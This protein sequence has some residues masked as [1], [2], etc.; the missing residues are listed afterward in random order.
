VHCG[1]SALSQAPALLLHRCG[2]KR[3]RVR[4]SVRAGVCRDPWARTPARCP[5]AAT[6]AR[7]CA[8]RAS[9][10]AQR[11]NSPLAVDCVPTGGIRSHHGAQKQGGHRHA[12]LCRSCPYR[13]VS[14]SCS[15]LPVPST[16]PFATYMPHSVLPRC[17]RSAS[18]ATASLMTK[19]YERMGVALHYCAAVDGAFACRVSNRGALVHGLSDMRCCVASRSSIP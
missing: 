13:L 18:T 1:Q 10:C 2:A 6:R 4:R 9:R 16:I 5:T 3:G 19:R 14:D 7:L 12:G 15:H 11:H 17:S 8:L